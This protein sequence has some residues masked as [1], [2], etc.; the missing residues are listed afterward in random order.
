MF[1]EDRGCR[2]Q[3]ESH[4]GP[5]GALSREDEDDIVPAGGLQVQTVFLAAKQGGYAAPVAQGTLK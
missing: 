5:L 2:H 4:T 1:P 3:F